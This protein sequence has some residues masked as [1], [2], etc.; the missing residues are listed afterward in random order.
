MTVEVV[1]AAAVVAQQATEEKGQLWVIVVHV[2]AILSFSIDLVAG[3]TI[4]DS[5]LNFACFFV[6][7]FSMVY[8]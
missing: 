8:F 7:D 3:V 2:A 4:L 6:E 5:A 1:T